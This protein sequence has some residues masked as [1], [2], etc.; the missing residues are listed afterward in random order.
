MLPDESFLLKGD[1]VSK[2]RDILIVTR[3]ADKIYRIG[4]SMP[5]GVALDYAV[6]QVYEV[7][8]PFPLIEGSGI[9]E[10]PDAPAWLDQRKKEGFEFNLLNEEAKQPQSHWAK[11]IDPEKQYNSEEIALLFKKDKATVE[12]W[13]ENWHTNYEPRLH[14]RSQL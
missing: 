6:V 5:P 13:M 3:T 9:V 10:T 2:Q 12:S 1:V 4:R 14:R 11:K 8:G 7:N